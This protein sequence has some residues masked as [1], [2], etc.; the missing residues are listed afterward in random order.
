MV[1]IVFAQLLVLQSSAV[2]NYHH[3]ILSLRHK[4]ALQALL[5]E[6]RCFPAR[7]TGAALRRRLRFSRSGRRA[8]DG[9]ASGIGSE[10]KLPDTFEINGSNERH[11][12]PYLHARSGGSGWRYPAGS[13]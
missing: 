4:S 1:L 7:S 3:V 6:G 5:T 13:F 10:K 9:K 8:G 11:G 12:Q 2:I